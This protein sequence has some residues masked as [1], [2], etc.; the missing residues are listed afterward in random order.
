[1]GFFFPRLLE[2]AKLHAWVLCFQ[3][4]PAGT[5]F[6]DLKCGSLGKLVAEEWLVRE[7]QIVNDLCTP[8]RGNNRS[9]QPAGSAPRPWPAET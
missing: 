5:I 6:E 7:L 4:R 8:K 9:G 1:M 3:H 2:S